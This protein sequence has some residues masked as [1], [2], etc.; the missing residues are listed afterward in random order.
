MRML[1][2]GWLIVAVGTVDAQDV[3]LTEVM[4]DPAGSDLTDE[5]VEIQYGGSLEVDLIGWA[6]GD[7]TDRDA[8]GVLGGGTL[9]GPG[10]RP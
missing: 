1:L 8:I 6:I 9:I 7:G 5:F 10:H 3:V 2:I 4:F